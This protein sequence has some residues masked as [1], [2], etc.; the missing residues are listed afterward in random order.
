MD[1]DF[2]MALSIKSIYRIKASPG[3]D[4]GLGFLNGVFF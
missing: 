3:R 4:L 2:F 1:M